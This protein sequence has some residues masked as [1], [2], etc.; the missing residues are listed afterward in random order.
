MK[1][2]TLKIG[3]CT[4][5]QTALENCSGDILSAIL[6]VFREDSFD[7]NDFLIFVHRRAEIVRVKDHREERF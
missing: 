7:L 2:H 3:S 1:N 5:T 6:S 4:I